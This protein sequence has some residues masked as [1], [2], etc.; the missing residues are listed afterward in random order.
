MTNPNH[1]TLWRP[2]KEIQNNSNLVEFINKYVCEFENTKNIDFQSILSWSVQNPE[3][4]WNYVWDYSKVI[5]TKG[6][7]L[8]KDKDKMPG[9]K[10]FP[11]SKTF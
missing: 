8:L 9:A 4:F 5:G 2:S 7:T 3:K 6:K 1:K 10:F 11:D